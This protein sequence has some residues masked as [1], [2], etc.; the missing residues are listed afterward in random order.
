MHQHSRKVNSKSADGLTERM[1]LNDRK[2][3]RHE[4]AYQSIRETFSTI[5]VADSMY[6]LRVMPLDDR[7]HR[8]A[9]M[10]DVAKSF[11]TG[12][13]VS[14]KLFPVFEQMMRANAY[15]RFRI[16]ID[17][18]YWRICETEDQFAR[19]TRD[20]DSA[21][22]QKVAVAGNSEFT[23]PVPPLRMQ[24]EMQT[25]SV[26]QTPPTQNAAIQPGAHV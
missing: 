21:G 16:G 10:I 14:A 8:F 5:A 24:P 11:F 3:F 20:G 26:E 19:A 22:T 25:G 1:C 18:I 23:L 12:K 2:A 15:K 9:A 13:E 6:K 7:H 17:G 4:M